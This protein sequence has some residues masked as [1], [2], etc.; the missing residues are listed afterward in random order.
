[1]MQKHFSLQENLDF[2]SDFDYD[3]AEY[4]DFKERC[5]KASVLTKHELKK[6]FPSC[7]ILYELELLG[8]ERYSKQFTIAIDFVNCLDLILAVLTGCSMESVQALDNYE[9]VSRDML[10]FRLEDSETVPLSSIIELDPKIKIWF[11]ALIYANRDKD[12]SMDLKDT[13]YNVLYEFY[14][15]VMDL[16]EKI[17]NY[18]GGVLSDAEGIVYRSKSY[19]SIILSADSPFPD[20][21]ITLEFEKDGKAYQK[22]VRVFTFTK[23]E[24]A[25]KVGAG[26][27]EYIM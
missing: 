26:E 19:S 10:T 14:S 7:D 3:S 20:E 11:T 15:A 25:R 24:Y 16:L 22:D 2:L 6:A 9:K 21:Y 18:V 12:D 5:Y 4:R 8:V 1:M 23:G 17:K 27:L 13:V